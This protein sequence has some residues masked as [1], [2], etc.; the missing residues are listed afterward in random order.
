MTVLELYDSP[1]GALVMTLMASRLDAVAA[2]A[3]RGPAVAAV[4]DRPL[5]VLVLQGVTFVDSTGLGC[6]VS[7]LKAL[8]SGGR[9][10]LVGVQ[11]AVKILF[12]LTRLERIF[13]MFPT[14]EEALVA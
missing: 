11:P 4:A 14:V 9:V 2:R 8:P 13:P 7:I 12:D 6:L 1:D 3:V 10:R 5:V